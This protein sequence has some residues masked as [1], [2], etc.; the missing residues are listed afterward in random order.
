[1]IRIVGT[2]AALTIVLALVFPFARDA[3]RRY[4]MTQKLNAVMD[5]SDRAALRDWNG[6]PQD[7][8]RSLYNRCVQTHPQNQEACDP[9]KRALE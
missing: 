9:Y 3:Y 8:G 2:A 4:E 5:D 1:M 6:S 7:F